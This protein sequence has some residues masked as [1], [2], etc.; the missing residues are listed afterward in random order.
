[1]VAL[2]GASGTSFREERIVELE[3]NTHTPMLYT[4]WGPIR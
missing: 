3:T 2:F 4:A 1:M